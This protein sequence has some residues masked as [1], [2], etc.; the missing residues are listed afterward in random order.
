VRSR[1][2]ASFTFYLV[3]L[4]ACGCGSGSGGASKGPA[5]TSPPAEPELE[6]SAEGPVFVPVEGDTVGTHDPAV[7]KEGD[8]YYMFFTGRGI[9]VRTS[10][11]LR[12][13]TAQADVFA[14]L[15]AW[16]HQELPEN[17]G[18]LWA[19]DISWWGG[20]WHLYYA[21]SVWVPGRLPTRDSAIGHATN[22]TLDPRSPDFEWIDHGPVVRSMGE[23]TD[24]DVSGWN[25]IDPNVVLDEHGKPWLA[26]G[27]AYDGIFIQPLNADGTADASHPPVNLARRAVFLL[28]IEASFIVRRDGWWYL[29]ASFDRCC[30]GAKSTYNVRVGRSRSLTGPYV[31]RGGCPLTEGGGTKVLAAYGGVRGP[32]H[33]AVLHDGSNWWLIHHWYDPTRG[34]LS[35]LG[36]RP[37]DWDA[38][39]WPTARGWSEEITL[40]P[41]LGG[42]P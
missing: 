41:P 37:L 5:V 11:D 26:W 42:R 21:A 35:D 24:A 31:D 25:A 13:W 4:G 32:G 20:E 10:P 29:F 36:I 14:S 34:G 1:S 19:P 18:D 7:A 15:P 28:V 39:G 23:L 8:T 12:H 16:V 6:T 2:L 3:V 22:R 30:L 40:P 17:I 27:S 38:D 33:E 9:R